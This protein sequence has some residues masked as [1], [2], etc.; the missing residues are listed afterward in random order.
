MDKNREAALWCQIRAGNMTALSAMATGHIGI[1]HKLAQI[2]TGDTDNEEVTEELISEGS[3][4]LVEAENE[5][6]ELDLPCCFSTY[7]YIRANRAMVSWRRTNHLRM[8][9]EWTARNEKKIRQLKDEMS[10]LFERLS[11]DGEEPTPEELAWLAKGDTAAQSD[12]QRQTDLSEGIGI[13]VE[14]GLVEDT[15]PSLWAHQEDVELSQMPAQSRH[16]ID[17][18]NGSATLERYAERHKFRN[19]A[20][21]LGVGEDEI[22]QHFVWANQAIGGPP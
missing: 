13:Q 5:F 15:E 11:L 19:I 4:A 2:H 9:S 10:T 16:L 3:V 7:L 22:V 17:T 8:P 20:D 12:V 21:A 6:A 14:I 18:V 1:V